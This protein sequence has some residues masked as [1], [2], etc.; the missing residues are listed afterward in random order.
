MRNLVIIM[1]I[2][3]LNCC[4]T[5]GENKITH[6]PNKLEINENSTIVCFG[7]SITYGKGA[8]S[9]ETSFPMVLQKKNNYS[10]NKFRRK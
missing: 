3:F 10:R 6:V 4:K 8:D 5:N 9:I 1:G 2:L 7:D